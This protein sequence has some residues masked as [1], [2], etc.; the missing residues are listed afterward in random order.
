MAYNRDLQEDKRAVFHAD[1]TLATALPA[2][3]GLLAT[4]EFHPPE[5][6][7]RTV[8]LDLAEALVKK[9]VPFRE[10]HEAVGRLIAGLG[11]SDLRSVSARQLSDT[12]PQLEP[13][14]LPVPG[15]AA[16]RRGGLAEQA[17]RLRH[18]LDG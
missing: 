14:D 3:G 7:D 13:T 8:A 4:A 11:G 6:D 12:H 2:I 17:G 9:G 18:A 1:D 16:K 10:A 15:Q 5:P